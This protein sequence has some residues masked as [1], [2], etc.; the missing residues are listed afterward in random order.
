MNEDPSQSYSIIIPCFNEADNLKTLID[1]CKDNLCSR[2]IEVLL[3]DNGSIDSSQEILSQI[4]DSEKY[5]KTYRLERNEGYGNGILFGLSRASGEYLGWTHADLQT[6]P[7]DVVKGFKL[8]S[9]K[10][11]FVK[12]KRKGR[13]F[14]E[15]FFTLGMAIFESIL[16]KE[17]LWEINAQPTLFHKDFYRMWQDPP[18]DFSL[19]LYAYSVAKK[20]NLKVKRLE[21]LFPKRTGGTSSWNTGIRSKIDL[22]KRTINYSNRLRLKLKELDSLENFPSK[23]NK[24]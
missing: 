3:I 7:L 1:V 11:D 2:K 15:N 9:S 6:S 10:K 16:L 22:I 13:N 21:V 24:D 14:N 23:S 8:I 20:Y 5:L 17:F 19:D 18:K 12:G 4:S